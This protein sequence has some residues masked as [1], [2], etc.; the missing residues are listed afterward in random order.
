MVA[1]DS[2]CE[3]KI[4]VSRNEGTALLTQFIRKVVMTFEYLDH[5]IQHP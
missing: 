1:P 4:S 5:V 2:L 3:S